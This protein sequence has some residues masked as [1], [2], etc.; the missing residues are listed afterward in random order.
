MWS[1]I[2][3]LLLLVL[4][5]PM[6]VGAVQ[7]Q[8]VDTSPLGSQTLSLISAFGQLGQQI[9][10]LKTEMQSLQ[11]SLTAVQQT[12]QATTLGAGIPEC[13]YSCRTKLTQCLT[14][15]PTSTS[16]LAVTHLLPSPLTTQLIT[17]DACR[18]NANTCMNACK[19]LAAGTVSCEDKCAV[20]LGGCIQAA[21]NDVTKLADCRKN[22]QQCLIAACQKNTPD[23]ASMSRIPTAVCGDQCLRDLSICREGAALD[24][25][26]L[27]ACDAAARTCQ[28]VLCN[29]PTS[30]ASVTSG[31]TP[32]TPVGTTPSQSG[33]QAP[34]QQITVNCENACTATFLA[35]R[36][37]NASS[38]NILATC[39]SG[40]GDC[41]NVCLQ[42]IG[43]GYA[44]AEKTPVTS[45]VPTSTPGAPA[46]ALP[47]VVY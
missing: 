10:A 2:A 40:Y 6:F 39:D 30:S 20:A 12:T 31:S 33:S 27:D 44:S 24:Q 45:P 13:L 47:N 36:Q 23:A 14:V 34:G 7:G 28:S 38:P 43:G 8:S 19:P 37:T 42:A 16:P 5:I 9:D 21:G 22:D 18:T 32:G 29:L 35:C 3:V 11:S 25:V 17:L 26:Q 46:G 15:H 4:S 41:R 1:G